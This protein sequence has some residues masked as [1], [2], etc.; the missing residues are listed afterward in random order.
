MNDMFLG[1]SYQNHLYA[2]VSALHSKVFPKYKNCLNDREAV[3]VA[4]GPTVNFYDPSLLKEATY[5]AVN[6]S[7]HQDKI[8][9]DWLFLQDYSGL[10]Q[11]VSEIP[12]AEN[13]KKAK[14][15]YGIMKPVPDKMLIP[16]QYAIRDGAERYI[17]H[18]VCYDNGKLLPYIDWGLD[19]SAE[20]FMCHGTIALIALQFLLYANAKKIYLVGCDCSTSGHFSKNMEKQVTADDEISVWQI[21]YKKFKRFAEIHYPDTEI[22]SVNPIGLTGLFHDVYTETFLTEHP[23]IDRNTVNVLK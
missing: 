8:D 2:S 23:E 9:F 17:A 16:E 11:S 12:S 14:K 15:F 1:L 22:I 5:V 3:I 10:K 21:G 18:S 7:F 20:P 19:L 6:G 13:L 4:S